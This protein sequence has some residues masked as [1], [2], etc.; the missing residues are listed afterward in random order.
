MKEEEKETE[1]A[2]KKEGGER[3]GGAGRHR[4]GVTDSRAK[5]ETK[6]EINKEKNGK[7]KKR[8]RR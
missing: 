5:H 4:S 7:G 3:R 1:S 2:L 6:Q 8:W